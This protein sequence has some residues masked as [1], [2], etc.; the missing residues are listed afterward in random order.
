MDEY[1]ILDI[2][3]AAFSH[4]FARLNDLAKGVPLVNF[5]LRALLIDPNKKSLVSQAPICL[6][7]RLDFGKCRQYVTIN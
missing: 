3:Y 4:V 5:P 7:S 1:A 6:P 2:K